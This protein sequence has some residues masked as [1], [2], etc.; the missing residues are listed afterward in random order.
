M[1]SHSEAWVEGLGCSERR[2]CIEEEK[3]QT[4]SLRPDSASALMEK[5][6][7]LNRNSGTVLPGPLFSF[8]S[9]AHGHT[10]SHTHTIEPE[11]TAPFTMG[12]NQTACQEL[13]WRSWKRRLNSWWLFVGAPFYDS[14]YEDQVLFQNM[15]EVVVVK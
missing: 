10:H 1:V 2:L 15:E 11:K 7:K 8:L 13:Q 12:L 4:V 6:E 9:G 14:F 3:I 5:E